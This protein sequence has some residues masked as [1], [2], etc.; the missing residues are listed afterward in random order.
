MLSKERMEF[1]RE[2]LGT[3]PKISVDT[4]VNSFAENSVKLLGLVETYRV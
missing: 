1:E 3:A 4:Y 2:L